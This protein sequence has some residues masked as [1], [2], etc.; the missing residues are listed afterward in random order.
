MTHKRQKGLNRKE[1]DELLGLEEETF[2]YPASPYDKKRLDRQRRLEIK[3]T[4]RQLEN[5]QR[6][7]GG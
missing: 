7:V 1:Y 4:A 6:K 3:A 5:I 2:Y